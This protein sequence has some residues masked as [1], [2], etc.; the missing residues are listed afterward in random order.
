M[1]TVVPGLFATPRFAGGGQLLGGD[2]SNCPGVSLAVP[3]PPPSYSALAEDP[4]N[5][6]FYVLNS[7]LRMTLKWPG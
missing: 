7:E 1:A 4:K 3:L 5:P 2:P 6:K